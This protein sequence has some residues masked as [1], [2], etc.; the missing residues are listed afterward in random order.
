MNDTLSYQPEPFQHPELSPKKG[1]GCLSIFIGFSVFVVAI[2]TAIWLIIMNSSV[3][4]RFVANLIEDGS[5]SSNLKITGVSGSLSSGLNFKKVKWDGG[6]IADMRF[7]YSGLMDVI[8]RDELIIY[9]MHVGSATFNTNDLVH[10]PKEEEIPPT[11]TSSS[12]S[13]ST[14]PPLRLLRIDRVSLNKIIITN[15]TTGETIN[16]PKIELNGFKAEKGKPLKFGDIVANSDH[17]VIKTSD[18]SIPDYQKRLEIT[19]MPKLNQRIRKPITIDALLGEKNDKAIYDIKA[20]DKTV[21]FTTYPDGNQ[22]IRAEGVNL[23][24]FID[25][26]LPN[27]VHLDATTTKTE[28]A[29]PTFMVR[30]GSFILGTKSFKIQPTTIT[31]DESKPEGIPFFAL[32]RA[33]DTEIRYEIP[34]T[35]TE[36]Q[37]QNLTPILTSNRAMSP[38]DLMALLYYD[39]KFST[40]APNN[41]EK[42]RK[43]ITW[44]SFTK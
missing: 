13:K 5:K 29:N 24:D 1:C 23:S 42:I 11:E 3:P 35:E 4:L 6:E 43:D 18:P 15:A 26:P 28:T 2:V 25:A 21:S 41:Q 32:H 37:E 34:I 31:V 39:L 10:P 17:L 33:G 22:Q 12:T 7:H 14:E 8:S 36:T 40:L 16:I 30:S 19:L 20:F 38:E 9:E 27:N 44:Y